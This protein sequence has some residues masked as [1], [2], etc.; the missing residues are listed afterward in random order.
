[1][2]CYS[3]RPRVGLADIARLLLLLVLIIFLHLL[4]LLL[5]LLL[6]SLLL[7]SSSSSFFLLLLSL[8]H[9]RHELDGS[10]LKTRGRNTRLMDAASNVRQTL[11][12]KP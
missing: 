5:L 12:P 11:N 9:L 7:S 8:L 2:P 3:G 1:M 6:L 4:L 10:Q